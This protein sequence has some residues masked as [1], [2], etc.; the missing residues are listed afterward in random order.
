M[1]P[2]TLCAPQPLQDAPQ[3]AQILD[4]QLDFRF[5]WHFLATASLT[6]PTAL[7]PIA[8]FR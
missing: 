6:V 4:A 3:C 2:A 8:N 5:F 1:G 7:S